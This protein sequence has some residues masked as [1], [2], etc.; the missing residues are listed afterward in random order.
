MAM[1]VRIL[2]GDGAPMFRLLYRNA[3]RS[4][5][6]N[7]RSG[8]T[9]PLFEMKDVGTASAFLN[10]ATF[11]EGAKG[12]DYDLNFLCSDTPIKVKV[13]N[14]LIHTLKRM[15]I[16]SVLA[17]EQLSSTAQVQRILPAIQQAFDTWAT[18]DT[19]EKRRAIA[20]TRYEFSFTFKQV[21]A[22]TLPVQ[23]RNLTSYIGGHLHLV[24]GAE[25]EAALEEQYCYLSVAHW[26]A[27][28][29][30]FLQRFNSAGLRYVKGN[31]ALTTRAL[32]QLRGTQN[33][34]GMYL[35]IFSF[36]LFSFLFLTLAF[37]FFK[38]IT[39]KK[40][41]ARVS[42]DLHPNAWKDKATKEFD[43]YYSPTWTRERTITC[44]SEASKRIYEKIFKLVRW[45]AAVKT[46]KIA[47]MQ[48]SGG[49]RA[50]ASRNAAKVFKKLMREYAD[51]CEEG[52][53]GEEE[54]L[55]E[56]NMKELSSIVLL[57]SSRNKAKAKRPNIKFVVG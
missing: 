10:G 4:W 19:N 11:V 17:K 44:P 16:Y 22:A 23:L 15:S 54:E 21:T 9:F 57:I 48:P 33:I 50:G 3:K 42:G 39:S 37:F 1:S 52:G 53:G 51:K 20:L 40:I 27:S 49:V 26:H 41:S 13:Y 45:R 56:V 25:D 30:A 47:L 29:P 43:N 6:A 46:D 35:F 7:H 24:F 2:D 18:Y 14:S 8:A 38:G 12:V 32:H 28:L 31:V 36:L 55:G 5:P 34:L